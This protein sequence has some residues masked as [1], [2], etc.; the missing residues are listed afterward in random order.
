MKLKKAFVVSKLLFEKF[1]AE[2]DLSDETVDNCSNSAFISILSPRK[3]GHKGFFSKSLFKKDHSNVLI[4]KFDDL[5]VEPPADKTK[6][7]YILFNEKM[8]KEVITFLDNN[9]DKD[10]FFIHCAAGISRSGAIGKFIMDF[11]EKTDKEHFESYNK[12]VLPNGLVLKL[13]NKEMWK[14]HFK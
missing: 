8:A 2:H 12:H 9:E 3:D 4:L 10:N 1:C 14:K 5:I 6:K 13:L 7:K 11:Y